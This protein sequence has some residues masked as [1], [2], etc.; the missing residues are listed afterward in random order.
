M[1][2]PFLLLACLALAGC[3]PIVAPATQPAGA[4][5]RVTVSGTRIGPADARP[6]AAGVVNLDVYLVDVP[7]GSVSGDEAFWRTV[8]E[9]AVGVAAGR[10]LAD[11]GIR[12]GVAPASQWSRFADAVARVQSHTRRTRTGDVGVT[13]ATP[14]SVELAVDHPVDHEDVWVVN[15]DGQLEGR[16][17][18]HAVN[19]VRLTFA[20]AP[21]RAATVRL[22][23][24]P[25]VKRDLSRLQ[26]TPLNQEQEQPATDVVCLYDAGLTAD[27]PADGF[28]V[29]APGPL[30]VTDPDTL[31][32]QFLV[33]PDPATRREQ[34][35]VAVPHY[36]P[37]GGSAE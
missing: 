21:R 28:F 1:I 8:D 30:A 10:R 35:I 19:G 9:N 33:R 17:F 7:I 11:N 22:S 24:C 15:A 16:T 5:P 25:T 23:F 32:G 26:F 34:V 6:A 18:D 13:S 3:D 12:C 29:V 37:L 27:V 20:P 36:T 2:R 31:G 14:Q 4:M